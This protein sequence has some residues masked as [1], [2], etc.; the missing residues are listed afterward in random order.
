MRELAIVRP[1]GGRGRVWGDFEILL[2]F[3]LEIEL[4]FKIINITMVSFEFSC[5]ILYSNSYASYVRMFML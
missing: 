5:L 2:L 3:Y 4:A 1:V